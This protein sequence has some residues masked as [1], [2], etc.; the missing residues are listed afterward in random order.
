MES[1]TIDLIFQL[2]ALAIGLAL[3]MLGLFA[4]RIAEKRHLA[5]LAAR[6]RDLASMLAIDTRSL[7]AVAAPGASIVAA[8]CVISSDY[9]KSFVA[10]LR[11][12]IGGELG[13]YR[14]LMDRARR[15][16]LVRLLEQ[17]RSAGYNA[18]TCIR[19]EGASIAGKNG[20]TQKKGV[21]MVAVI[22]YGTA[23]HTDAG[24]PK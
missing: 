22:A 11:K 12:I 18:V 23:Y 14:S 5:R 15:E 6:E 9:F 1:D 16:A 17:A 4:G 8:E 24:D 10:K 2:I 19:L 7:P 3:L 21:I 20:A 13:S